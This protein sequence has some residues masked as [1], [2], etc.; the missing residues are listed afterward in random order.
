MR[1]HASVMRLHA[2]VKNGRIEVSE[3]TDLPDGETVELMP[4]AD[5]GDA[6]DDLD[7]DERARLHAAIERGLAEVDAGA[8]LD[9]R[10]VLRQRRSK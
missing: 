1:Y 3:P 4:I 5:V 7:E 2:V 10:V 9:A 6:H 8:G